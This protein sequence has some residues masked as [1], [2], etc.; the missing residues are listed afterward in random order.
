[1]DLQKPTPL[2]KDGPKE[3]FNGAGDKICREADSQNNN[4]VFLAPVMCL[5]SFI[6]NPN[7]SQTL[8]DT[9]TRESTVTEKQKVRKS[10]QLLQLFVEGPCS[11]D[12]RLLML[13]AF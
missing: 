1:M 8:D 2:T 11:L 10:T 9:I 4:L 13:K 12:S 7:I 5:F 3:S 6:H